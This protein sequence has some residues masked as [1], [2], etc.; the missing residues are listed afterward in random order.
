MPD[1]GTISRYNSGCKCERCRA[2]KREYNQRYY[3][4]AHARTGARSGVRLMDCSDAIDEIA[5]LLGSG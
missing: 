1:H 2:K 5:L 4:K 3:D